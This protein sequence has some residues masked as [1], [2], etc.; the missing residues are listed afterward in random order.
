MPRDSFVLNCSAHAEESY[1]DGE[2]ILAMAN[3]IFA[4]EGDCPV[5]QAEHGYNMAMARFNATSRCGRTFSVGAF[6]A[7]GC[8]APGTELRLNYNYS[9]DQVRGRFAGVAH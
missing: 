1:V 6:F 5:A 8:I 7:T 3:T 9:P 4:Y 2:N